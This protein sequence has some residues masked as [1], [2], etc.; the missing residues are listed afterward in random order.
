MYFLLPKDRMLKEI[1]QAGQAL[2]F[3]SSC[4]SCLRA[5]R[6][7]K[8]FCEFI[9]KLR[10]INLPCWFKTSAFRPKGA[11]YRARIGEGMQTPSQS[12]AS[13]QRDVSLLLVTNGFER[14]LF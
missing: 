1:S 2:K 9:Q 14:I 8:Y 13:S 10:F 11:L 4:P 6:F 3:F 5:E 7:L 12:L